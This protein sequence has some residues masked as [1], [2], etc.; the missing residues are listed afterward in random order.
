[1]KLSK[2][3]NKVLIFI[4]IILI[5]SCKNQYNHIEKYEVSI[6]SLNTLPDGF[7]AHRRG[8]IYISNLDSNNCMVWFNRKESG[9]IHNIFKAVDTKNRNLCSDSVVKKYQIDTIKYIKYASRFIQLSRKYK[10]GH[11]LINRKNKISFSY[12]DGKSEEYVK[13]FDDDIEK[14]YK[15]NSDFKL[16]DNGWFVIKEK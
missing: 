2:S 4:Y 14:K 3:I 12:I 1:M 8:N 16:L 6:D 11:I 15:Q 13:T 5:V 10:F 7:Y 9:E